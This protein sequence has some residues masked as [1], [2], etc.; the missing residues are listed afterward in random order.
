L[1]QHI[2]VPGVGTVEF[3]DGTSPQIM[4][5]A[6]QR[7]LSRLT[8]NGNIWPQY[9]FGQNVPGMLV[10]GNIDIS[11]RLGAKGDPITYNADGSTSTVFSGSFDDKFGRQVLVPFVI[12]DGAGGYK[13]GT[14]KEARAHYEKTGEHLGIFDHYANADQYAQRL[15]EYLANQG[16][17]GGRIRGESLPQGAPAMAPFASQDMNARMNDLKPQLPRRTTD[18]AQ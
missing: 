6:I 16:S 2:S 13:I 3:P 12:P 5:A 1:P 7:H 9:Q 11:R 14:E 15:H 4:T 10:P 8:V 17:I 18:S